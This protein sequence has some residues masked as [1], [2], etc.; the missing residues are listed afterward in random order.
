MNALTKSLTTLTLL[1]GLALAAHPAATEPA[2][3]LPAPAP[4]QT[5]LNNLLTLPAGPLPAGTRL[6]SLRI[7][8]GLATVN[9]SHEFVD[10]FS[11]GD[12]AETRALNSVLQTL[13]QFPTVSRAQILVE[14]RAIDSLGGLLVLTDPLPVIRPTAAPPSG[15]RW[16]HRRTHVVSKHANS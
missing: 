7:T 3:P 9:F 8:D 14:G 16:L 4:A 2:I 6:L 15:L 5:A 1:A 11:G 13:G 10:N 12:T